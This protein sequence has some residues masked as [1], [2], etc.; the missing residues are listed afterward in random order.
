[1]TTNPRLTGYEL[2]DFTYSLECAERNL[3]DA[4]E[5]T[6]HADLKRRLNA[7]RQT[8]LDMVDDYRRDA[9]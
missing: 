7:M 5:A 8:L 2:R 1:M 9:E 6:R 3:G 4:A